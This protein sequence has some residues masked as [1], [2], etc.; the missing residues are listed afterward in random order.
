MKPPAFS[1]ACPESLPEALEL[2]A[3]YGD[4][5]KWLAGGQS[6]IAVLNLRFAEPKVLI[7]LNRIPGLAF[8]A[9][10]GGELRIGAMTRHRTLESSEVASAAQPLVPR[11]ARE[12]GHLAIRNRG[13]IGGSLV[14]GDPAAEWPLVTLVM[15]ARLRLESSG[16][17]REI[18]A[19]DFWVGPLTSVTRPG[20]LVTEIRIGATSPRTS[21]GFAELCRRPGDFAIVAAACRVTRDEAGACRDVALAVGGA[22]ATALRIG[23]A[24]AVVRGNRGE[25]GAVDDAAEAAMRAVEPSSDVHA[26]AAYR[27]RMVG[28]LTRRV[29][30]EAL[31]GAGREAR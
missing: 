5:A 22:D 6:L 9:S 28:V 1:Y 26:S 8:V 10:D 29:L 17:A 12:I 15:G 20:E 3:R 27:R 7:D 2:G 13:T 14:H 31:G 19:Q 18:A 4:D 21:F 30:H 16:G 24:E 25:S 23:A 11:A